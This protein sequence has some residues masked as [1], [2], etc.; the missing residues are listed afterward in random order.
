MTPDDNCERSCWSCRSR[1]GHELKLE[2][3]SECD[4][5]EIVTILEKILMKERGGHYQLA[6]E[7]SA[8]VRRLKQELEIEAGLERSVLPEEMGHEGGCLLWAEEC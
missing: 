1:Q 6:K 5:V 2:S 7:L 8:D 4:I 3:F